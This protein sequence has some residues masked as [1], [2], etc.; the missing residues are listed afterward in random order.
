[1]FGKKEKPK[2]KGSKRDSSSE[3][4]SL[5]SSSG[6]ETKKFSGREVKLAA[7]KE[8]SSNGKVGK[9]E[10]SKAA[11]RAAALK[12][13]SDSESSSS[14]SGDSIK[15]SVKSKEE[16]KME[17][18]A[19]DY[20]GDVAKENAEAAG[21]DAKVAE[22]ASKKNSNI[23]SEDS[24]KRHITCSAQQVRKCPINDKGKLSRFREKESFHRHCH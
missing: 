18:K 19:K 14:G 11:S 8:K 23:Q 10:Q 21:E 7:R 5:D 15:L 17:G 3:S 2:V 13:E 24:C 12:S 9:K 1:M 22:R 16:R 20:E 4:S 6:E